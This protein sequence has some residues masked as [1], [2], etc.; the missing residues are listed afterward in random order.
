MRPG[1]GRE[2]RM[3]S[4]SDLSSGIGGSAVSLSRQASERCRPTADGHTW[5]LML[6]FLMNLGFAGGGEGGVAAPEG[7]TKILDLVT[8]MYTLWNRWRLK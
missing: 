5:A 3:G 1:H 2:N 4:T 6:Y 7:G 8:Q